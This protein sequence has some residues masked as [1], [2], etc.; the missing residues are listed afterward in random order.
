[1]HAENS[2]RLGQLDESLAQLQEQVRK[3]PANPKLR[4]F[5]FQLLA[6]L[7]RWDRALAQ[8]NVAGELDGG[9]L[10]MVQTYREAIRCE[11]LREAVFAGRHTPLLLGEPE[12]WLALLFEALRL[13][14][15]GHGVDAASLRNEAFDLAPAA[16]GSINGDSFDWIA[17]ADSRLGPAIEV[18]LNGRY[19]WV[20]FNRIAQL[21][22]EPPSD[23][24]DLV[25]LP[26]QFTWSNGGSAAGLIPSRYPGS[27]MSSDS[28]IRLARKT[29][30][31]EAESGHYFGLGQREFIT[32]S[33]EHPLLET[34]QLVFD[35]TTSQ[36]QH[37]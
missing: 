34:R 14:A 19:Y 26:A 1:M 8:L 3:E 31:R 2:L 17:D 4:V 18:I 9:N 6:V 15:D 22:I 23:L 21:Q 25:W 36:K 16:K 35:I 32:G 37:G 30:W 7:G 33:G 13:E 12:Q 24:R 28:S 5:L 11:V 10:L 29:E 27:A 20:P